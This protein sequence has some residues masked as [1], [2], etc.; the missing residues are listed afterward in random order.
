MNLT[1][2]IA[3]RIPRPE[4]NRRNA[5]QSSG[6]ITPEA[7][8]TGRSCHCARKKKPRAPLMPCV[9]VL[10][11]KPSSCPPPL[12][13]DPLIS[14]ALAQAKSLDAPSGLFTRLSLYEQRLNP[15]P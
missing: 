13:A 8:R 6:P 4:A 10:L 7:K 14:S 11:D 12:S 1:S 3:L 5:A 15:H 9:T 2:S